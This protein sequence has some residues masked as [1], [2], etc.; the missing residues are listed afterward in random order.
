MFE[1]NELKKDFHGSTWGWKCIVKPEF[2]YRKDKSKPFLIEGCSKWMQ[3][4]EEANKNQLL[5][6]RMADLFAKRWIFKSDWILFYKASNGIL[7]YP[8][9]K[10]QGVMAFKQ[11]YGQIKMIVKVDFANDYTMDMI[12]RMV[13]YYNEGNQHNVPLRVVS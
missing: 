10:E 4:K 8:F 11:E 1:K 9:V 5:L 13:E 6:V 2:D 3:M 7:I 12:A